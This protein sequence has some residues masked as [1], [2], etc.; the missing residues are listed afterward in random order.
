V[1]AGNP[2]ARIDLFF[3]PTQYDRVTGVPFLL[4]D[5]T[6]FTAIGP[7]SKIERSPANGRLG[8]IVLKNLVAGA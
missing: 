1:L 8:S 4:R 2:P 5:E 6:E 7:Y 3:T